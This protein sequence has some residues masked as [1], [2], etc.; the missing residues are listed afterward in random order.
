MPTRLLCSAIAFSLVLITGCGGGKGGKKPKNQPPVFT[1]SASA[2]VEENTSGVFYQALATDPEGQAI[3]YSIMSGADSDLFSITADTGELS[4]ISPPDY[5]APEDQDGNNEYL[6]TLVADAGDDD[7]SILLLTISVT[8]VSDLEFRVTFPTPKGNIGGFSQTHIAGVVIDHEDGEVL[9]G[10][11]KQLDVNGYAANLT[12]GSP[13]RWSVEIPVTGH[14]IEVTSTITF[15]D[16]T[17]AQDVRQLENEAPLIDGMALELD[18][19][20]GRLLVGGGSKH[21]VI[22]EFD[23]S[24]KHGTMLYGNASG[25]TAL[26]AGS[27]LFVYDDGSS[28]QMVGPNAL[29]GVTLY[30]FATEGTQSSQ[31]LSAGETR[32]GA[33]DITYNAN[34][35][36]AIVSYGFP[37]EI[38]SINLTSGARTTLYDNTTGS[39]DTPISTDELAI[40]SASNLLYVSDY[41][42]IFS[43][44]LSNLERSY[45]SSPSIGT[46]PSLSG[47]V[48]ISYDPG[49]DII[50]VTEAGR[51]IT[52]DP[53]SGNR[54]ILSDSSTGTGEPLVAARDAEISSDGSTLY[55]LNNEGTQVLAV[56]TSTGNR[57][58]FVE[59]RLGTGAKSHT[60][61]NAY[62][63][64]PANSLI[65][66][67]GGD[68]KI[69]AINLS[70]GDRTEVSSSLVGMGQNLSFPNDITPYDDN[71]ALVN[72]S[73]TQNFY[74]IDIASGNRTT[75]ANN[76]IGFGDRFTI[77][78]M[79][80]YRSGANQLFV[81]DVSQDAIFSVDT[82]TGYRTIISN[83]TIGTGAALS[84]ISDIYHDATTDNLYVSD[85]SLKAMLAINP[86]SGNRTVIA[87][88]VTGS[89]T[90]ITDPRQISAGLTS[91]TLIAR[92]NQYGLLSIDKITGVRKSI[93]EDTS[94]LSSYLGTLAPT[95]AASIIPDA[96]NN[97]IYLCGGNTGFVM[98]LHPESGQRALVSY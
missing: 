33:K 71:S 23:M 67:T 3:S 46:G 50:Y 70:S 72:D 94:R 60:L 73:H 90:S 65:A 38:V 84:N 36:S 7:T 22:T 49:A 55:I 69:I 21:Q 15:H 26:I 39:G 74:L 29:S 8:D 43:V 93:P 28:I 6:I 34:Q 91:S 77:P 86:E 27:D 5:E 14:S 13:L 16:D 25:G 44:N 51:V 85:T 40:D 80:S 4:F 75:V 88:S 62:L 59:G 17:V 9:E 54:T 56:S 83:A 81:A 11:V 61:Q 89:G 63:N 92:D 48:A 87:N 53:A 68:A 41:N 30:Q 1:S 64:R 78:S 2:S 96:D 97:V 95:S 18:E 37:S 58:V 82:T 42:A 66:T 24:T 32:F 10:D 20:R 35:N 12:Y 52:I 98:V 79:I 19:A 47:I 57:T 31:H 76:D 45:V